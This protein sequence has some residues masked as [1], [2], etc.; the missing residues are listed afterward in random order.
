M[1]IF[2]RI[3]KVE[4]A[5]TLLLWRD[6][7][8]LPPITDIPLKEF[9][10]LVTDLGLKSYAANQL[11]S[12]LYKRRAASFDDMTN[13]AKSARDILR[14]RFSIAAV[15]LDKMQTATDGTKK[16]LCRAVDDEAVE[17]VLIPAEDGRITVCLSTQVGC[18][19][20]CAFCRTASMG[21]RR[22]S[23]QGEIL[24]QLIIAIRHASLD[25]TNL[26]LM[27]MG[28]PLANLK[29]V[30]AAID[31]FLDERAFGLSKR[32]VT[33][34]TCG[35]L[36]ELEEF[37]HTYDIKIAISLNATTDEVRQRL[38]P[39]TKKYP[40]AE[41]M[42]FCKSYSQ[43]SHYRITFEYVLIREI[44][45]TKEDAKRLVKLLAGVRGKIN[46]IPFNPFEGS[47]FE[48]SL[49]EALKWWQEFLYTNGIQAN[50]RA[51]RGQG[52][53]A[54]CGQLAVKA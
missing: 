17:C 35:L 24:G 36:P 13:L 2:E 52:I 12:W 18:A 28:E 43:R 29:A 31:V 16:F 4:K 11:I 41:L 23:T 22:N 10:K 27:G 33:L 3:A 21:L 53:L 44:N 25:V 32:R 34:S 5:S 26:V 50:I 39:I 46:L 1:W 14:S 49:P 54:A 7:D 15:E 20:G 30:E 40:I 42:K 51:S 6:L 19:M 9:P 38:M 37:S 45:D 47:K 48:A 8:M